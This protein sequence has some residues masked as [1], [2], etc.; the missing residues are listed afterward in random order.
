VPLV[1]VVGSL[2]FVGANA[3]AGA[4][5]PFP[6]R[7]ATTASL[8]GFSRMLVGAG[9]GAVLAL[10]HDGTPVPMGYLVAALGL[11]SLLSCL[12]LRSATTRVKPTI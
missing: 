1:F 2:G 7:A 9:A 12:M 10:I 5:E 11:L 4:M 3:L 8:L 6:N